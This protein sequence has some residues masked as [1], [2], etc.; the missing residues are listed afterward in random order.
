MSPKTP[1][2]VLEHQILLYEIFLKILEKGIGIRKDIPKARIEEITVKY[3][4]EIVKYR[5]AI[6]ILKERILPEEK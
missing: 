1:I 5:E 4:G 6:Q 3:R 2:E